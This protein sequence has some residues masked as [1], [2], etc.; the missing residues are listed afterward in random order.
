MAELVPL[1]VLRAEYEGSD[2][3]IK[4]IDFLSTQGYDGIRRSREDG[5]CF[6]RCMCPCTTLPALLIIAV[7]VTLAL[8][9]AYIERIFDKKDKE[10]AVVTSISTLEESLKSLQK[11]GFDKSVIEEAYEEPSDLIHRHHRAGHCLEQRSDAN[12][13]ANCSR[14]SKT[15][16]VRGTK[17]TSCCS[18]GATMTGVPFASAVS[19]YMVMFIR[20]V[21]SAQIQGNPEE[22]EPFLNYPDL[23]EKM[24]VEDFCQSGRSRSGREA[25]EWRR[26]LLRAARSISTT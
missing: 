7:W 19:N 10:M 17:I 22:Y 2:S 8:A 25:G 26:S 3:F 4:Q 15:T 9:F 23:G 13:R 18:N 1:S 12:T 11:V 16:R 14:C 21:T 6:Y 20:M 24:R 5:D